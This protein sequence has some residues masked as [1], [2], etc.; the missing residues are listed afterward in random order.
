MIVSHTST[1]VALPI[2]LNC[3]WLKLSIFFFC[4]FCWLYDC[5]NWLFPLWACNTCSWSITGDQHVLLYLLNRWHNPR[6]S[7]ENEKKK[8][9]H[10][11]EA[12]AKI[13]IFWNK[14][15]YEM[16]CIVEISHI[17][18]FATIKWLRNSFWTKFVMKKK[19]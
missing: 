17:C 3:Y 10:I 14:C 16:K 13:S 12:I 7:K 8:L 18:K 19:T 6:H 15:Q 5:L 4:W 2:C 1:G 11:Y 9:P